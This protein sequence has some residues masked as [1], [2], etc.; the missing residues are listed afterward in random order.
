MGGGGGYIFSYYLI[1]FQTRTLRIVCGWDLAELLV[2]LTAN[3]ATVL[4][5]IPVASTDTVESDGRQMKQCWKQYIEKKI[6]KILLLE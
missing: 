6:Q 3:V 2:R 4:D 5:S 1:C